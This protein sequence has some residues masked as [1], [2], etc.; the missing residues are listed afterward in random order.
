MAAWSM[1]VSKPRSEG[2]KRI[3]E[4]RPQ[5]MTNLRA[6]DRDPQRLI[7]G[8]ASPPLSVR[9]PAY[10]FSA[11]E[12]GGLLGRLRE[13]RVAAPWPVLVPVVWPRDNLHYLW[14]KLGIP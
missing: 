9:A 10:H 5:A 14:G 2:L 3:Q 7:L 12:R 8:Y 11:A 6:L 4:V 1:V 13:L